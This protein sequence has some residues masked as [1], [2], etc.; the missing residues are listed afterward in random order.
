MSD[1]EMK[2]QTPSRILLVTPVWKDAERLGGFGTDLAE[3]LAACHYDVH[4]VIADD[5][6]GAEQHQKLQELHQKLSGVYPKVSLHFAK[7]HRGKGSVVREAWGIHPEANWLAFVDADGSLAP[8]ELLRMFAAAEQ[9][10]ETVLAIRKRTETTDVHETVIRAIAH[11]LFILAVKT[12]VGV[13]CEDPQC[14]AKVLRGSDYRAVAE[15]L[16]E[17]GLAFD[18]E[19]LTALA[20]SGAPW[21]ELPVT[22]IEKDG[23]KVNPMR[24]AWGMLA[25]L[26]KI[27]VRQRNG[28]FKKNEA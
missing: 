7:E 19:M 11:R 18:A 27:R 8:D 22:W 9:G 12:L 4:W 2:A 14:G 5:G 13:Q 25:A 1:L 21:Q 23:G 20:A 6:S 15:S 16:K 24:D 26:W 10:G 17:D 28:E 3:T